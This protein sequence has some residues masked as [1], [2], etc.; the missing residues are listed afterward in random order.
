MAKRTWGDPIGSGAGSG[1]YDNPIS[2]HRWY[3]PS[4]ASVRAEKREEKIAFKKQNKKL[5]AQARKAAAKAEKGS[6]LCA[7][8]LMASA[9]GAAGLASNIAKAKGWVA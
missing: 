5:N 3:D 2:P 9:I 7:S 8:I 4:N 1:K 6:T